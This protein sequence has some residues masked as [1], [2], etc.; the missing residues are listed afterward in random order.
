MN[1]KTK[2]QRRPAH[3]SNWRHFCVKW[4]SP[5]RLAHA[6]TSIYNFG[7]LNSDLQREIYEQNKLLLTQFLLTAVVLHITRKFDLLLVFNPHF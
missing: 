6:K 3:S 1:Q 4:T 5:M 2:H 7:S